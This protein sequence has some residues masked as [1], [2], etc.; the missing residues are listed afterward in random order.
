MPETP[1][2]EHLSGELGGTLIKKMRGRE[3]PE[4]ASP[5]TEE[6]SKLTGTLITK[7][8]ESEGPSGEHS[9]AKLRG[10]L[11]KKMKGTEASG[12]TETELKIGDVISVNELRVQTPV[13]SEIYSGNLEL[14]EIKKKG[15]SS[16]LKIGGKE[17][18]TVRDEDY[19]HFKYEKDGTVRIC[20]AKESDVKSSINR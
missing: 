4:D 20:T 18:T 10:T 15:S 1:R 16:G 3:I 19:Y 8:R 13:S 9:F 2:S 12:E 17:S 11:I 7:T 14:T 6:P 5:R